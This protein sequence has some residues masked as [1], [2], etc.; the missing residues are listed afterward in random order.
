MSEGGQ[1]LIWGVRHWMVAML[2]TRYVPPSV[3]RS[4][5]AIGGSRFYRSLTA[6][7]L[8]AA[9]DADRPLK[10][11]PPCCGELSPDE[12]GIARVLAALTNDSPGAAA[13]HFRALL[14]REPST[15]LHRYAKVIAAR[16]KAA[17][18]TVGFGASPPRAL[19]AT[20]DSSS[21]ATHGDFR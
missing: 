8:L 6:L 1:L 15:A 4:F 2:E 18:M 9:R 20:A 3:L 17:G 12:E 21:L 19:R 5:E 13:V 11:H 7:V 10:I 14:G 16:F